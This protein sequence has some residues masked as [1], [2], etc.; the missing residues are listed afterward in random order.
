MLAYLASVDLDSVI[1]F[2]GA[3][4]IGFAAIGAVWKGFRSGRP[5]ATAMA[6]AV[7]SAN[8]RAV[9]LAPTFQAL[10][11]DHA[12]INGRLTEVQD[13]LGELRDMLV[14]IEDRTRRD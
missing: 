1:G 13:D 11:R 7:Q 6:A 2:A 4:G 5:T 3:I 10:R 12:D 14:R 8:C 9:D